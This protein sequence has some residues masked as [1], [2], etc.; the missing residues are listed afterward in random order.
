MSLMVH[1]YKKPGPK[2]AAAIA[3]ILT[4]NKIEEEGLTFFLLNHHKKVHTLMKDY[5]HAFE[6]SRSSGDREDDE[7]LRIC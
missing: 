4:D 2:L 7:G 5:P 1:N 3:G 6:D